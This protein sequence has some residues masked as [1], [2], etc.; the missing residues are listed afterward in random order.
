MALIQGYA[1]HAAGAEL[2]PFKYDPGELNPYDV[3]VRVTHCGVCRS[4]A[5]LIDNDW[6]TSQYPLV[7]GHEIVGT[8][9]AL[10]SAVHGLSIGERVGIG[11]QA[12]SC[13][14]C[15]WCR[16]GKENLCATA[17]PTC[18]H[19]HGGFAEA[20]RVNARFAIRLPD[21]LNSETSAPLMCAGITVY[22]PIRQMGINPSS[23]VGIIG[24]GGLG[25]LAIQFARVFGAEVTAFSTSAAKEQEA[26]E[27]GAHH[28]VNSRESKSV[29]G[30]AGSFDLIISTINADLDWAAFVNTLRPHGTLCFVG[31]PA[32]PISLPAFPLISVARS[33]CGSN[34]GSPAGIA[35]MLDV[36]A[37]HGVKAHIEKF[38]MSDANQ[39][40]N[41]LRKSQIR[42]RAVLSA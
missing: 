40:V 3:E 27:L 17:Q 33:V 25:H 26:L 24:I 11:W 13:G 14:R 41:R 9:S 21:A 32:K 2:L 38:K 4:D 29:N 18:V 15:E 8:V 5:S 22:T 20:L 12:N 28:F 34:T 37:R 36:A 6:G 7:P 10:G 42:Y 39:A 19:R 35:E 1:A 23:R 31:A 16:Q 30:L